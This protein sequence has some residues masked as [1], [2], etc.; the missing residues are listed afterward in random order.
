L[1]P[2]AIKKRDKGQKVFLRRIP[3]YKTLQHL[4]DSSQFLTNYKK[5]KYKNDKKILEI[6]KNYFRNK[7]KIQ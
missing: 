1:T 2:I 6:K 3:I 5:I 7:K 4:A